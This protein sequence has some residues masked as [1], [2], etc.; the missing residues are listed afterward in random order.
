MY[1]RKFFLLIAVSLTVLSL[2]NSWSQKAIAKG[3]KEITPEKI[4]T[5][6]NYLAS[7][8]LLGRDTPSPGQDSAASYITKAFVQ[9]GLAPVN[10]SYLAPVP[11]ITT[12]LG[13]DN[14][15]EVTVRGV[16]KNLNIKTDFI[17]FETS[18]SGSI[19]G[20]V[21]FAGYGITAPE[22]GYNDY[23][24]IDAKGKIVLIL[25][26][27]PREKDTTKIF[28]KYKSLAYKV[29]NAI[30]HGCTGVLVMT[31]PLN[32]MILSPK[33]FPWPT[34]YKNFPKEAVALTL[35]DTAQKKIPLVHV[36]KELMNILFGSVDSLKSLETLIDNELKPRSKEYT[37]ITIKLRV[38][39]IEN[40]LKTSNV[41]GYIAGSD[42]KLKD[43]LV[44]VG[45]HYD[46][47][48]FMKQHK[49]GERYIFNG[50]DD[51]ASGTSG[52]LAVAEAFSKSKVKPKRS[53]LFIAF[54][55][56]EK[57]LYGSQAYVQNPLFT[58]S[59]TV[60]MLNMDM[61]GRG[62]PDTLH[63]EAGALSP[64]LTA[65]AQ[66]E[67][68]DIG[69]RI[70]VDGTEFLDRSD[71][72]SFYH[73][74]IP[75]IMFFAGLHPDYHTVRDLPETID[76]LKASKIARLVLKTAWTVANDDKH[77]KLIE[78]K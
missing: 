43:E 62:N 48:G 77:Y 44:V 20:N 26:H 46:H 56:E 67:N 14:Q 41:V 55:A 30:T 42:P 65:I 32:H 69:F 72:S 78:S 25:T 19:E 27:A 35:K 75:F 54:T 34:L 61:I 8:A 59:N 29:K 16:T 60:A 64:D 73:K 63:L 11:L 52:L 12:S 10:G 53:V 28:N 57:G 15:L 6:I 71:Q 50:A 36:G 3:L 45:A 24:G 49:E 18:S 76:T 74:N 33:G 13:D 37:G 5:H 9:Y 4:K 70:Q 38:N 21:V 66:K 39:T 51:N 31:D 23:F 2:Q 1:L 7:D 47:V 40:R 22:L 68:A 58:L 17:P